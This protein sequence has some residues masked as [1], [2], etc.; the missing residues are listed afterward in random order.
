MRRVR[1]TAGIAALAALLTV[2]AP[3]PAPAA[4]NFT[5]AQK[6]AIEKIIRDYLVENP[7]VLRDALMALERQQQQEQ[8]AQTSQS[9][10]DNADELFRSARDHVVGNPDGGV[11][12]VEFFDY[13]CQF[14]KRSLPDVLKLIETQKDLRMVLK[15]F[16]ILGP[17]SLHASRAAIAS[18]KQGR[19]WEFHLA[20]ME[21]RGSID[22]DTVYRIAG[23]VGLDVARLK[24]DMEGPEVAA[25]IGANHELANRLGI[26][27]T[28]AFVVAD[29]LIPGAL[30]YEALREEIDAARRSETCLTC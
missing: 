3:A 26:Q 16:P 29:Q 9:I 23:E 7:T 13:N 2:T 30:G 25:I 28:P 1:H 19:Y 6:T 11:T 14:C 22:E 20:M 24:A 10:R 4:E 18:K 27:G 12:M 15:E 8:R 17:G 21:H 5:P